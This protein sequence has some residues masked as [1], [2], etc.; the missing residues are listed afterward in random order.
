MLAV[1]LAARIHR[2]N[3]EPVLEQVPD[4]V[5][6]DGESLVRL[7]GA[8]VAHIDVTV[9]SGTFVHR[10][11]LPYVPGT[12]GAGVI[13]SSATLAFGTPVR[14]RGGGVGFE[15]DGTWAELAAV[16]DATLDPLPEDTDPVVGAAFMSP[17]VTADLAVNRIGALASGERV[18]VIGAAGAVGHVC[19]QLALRGGASTV[20]GV[21]ATE[22]RLELIPDGA[23]AAGGLGGVEPVDLLV[24]TAGGPG[25][26]GRLA[27]VRPEGRLVLVGYA[28][29]TEATLDLPAFL[30][31]DVR[32][33]PVNLIRWEE[34]MRPR[35]RE[36]LGLV[37]QGRLELP[38]TELPL[39]RAA[40][41][42]RAVRE[43]T[44]FGRVALRIGRTSQNAGYT[45]QGESAWTR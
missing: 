33:L 19:A 12:D 27:A 29:G 20:V 14:V 17:C 9:A 21:E 4:P 45:E 16:P 24:D 34:R 23:E 38:L 41:A 5:P 35:A 6:G 44:A 28:S 40:A 13:V 15:R 32:L 18:A 43:G 1:V 2:W 8:T 10:P 31:A 3:G 36:L 11:Q 26:Q 25:L 7:G 22:A 30:A 42:L 37:T 39:E